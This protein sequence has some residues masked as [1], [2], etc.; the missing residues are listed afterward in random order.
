M[1]EPIALGQPTFGAEELAALAAVLDSGWVAGQGPVAADFE[2]RFAELCH[3]QH[4]LSVN[5]CTAALH[6]AIQGLG[7]GPGDEVVVAD[8][9]FP[10]T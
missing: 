10:A 9:T 5:N 2:R 6:L 3:A 4:S 7:A 8:Y 1:Q